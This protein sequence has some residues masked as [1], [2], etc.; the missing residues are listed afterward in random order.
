MTTAND[1]RGHV[2]VVVVVVVVAVDIVVVVDG[3]EDLCDDGADDRRGHVH[4][5]SP[6]RQDRKD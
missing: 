3:E 2:D 6:H 5:R 1:K 4:R